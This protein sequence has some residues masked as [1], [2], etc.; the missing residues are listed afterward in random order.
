MTEATLSLKVGEIGSLHPVSDR[1]KIA[2][3]GMVGG[4][5]GEKSFSLVFMEGSI[6]RPER[7]IFNLFFPENVEMIELG[8]YRVSV[9]HL[10]PKEITLRVVRMS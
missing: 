10:S 6:V 9:K 1:D 3:A 8:D 4:L 2:Y 5:I 7:P